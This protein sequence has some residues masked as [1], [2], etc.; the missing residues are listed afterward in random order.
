MKKLLEKGVFF[1][2]ADQYAPYS[3]Q[4]ETAQENFTFELIAGGASYAVTG[5]SSVCAQKDLVIPSF[6]NGLPVTKIKEQAFRQCNFLTSVVISEGITVIGMS[7]FYECSNLKSVRFPESLKVIGG[8]SFHS[9]AKLERIII[10]AKVESI[11]SRAFCACRGVKEFI[12]SPL[13]AKYQAIDGNLYTKDGTALLY[14]GVA[15]G[16]SSF[17]L[18]DGVR[19]IEEWAFT[20]ANALTE[21]VLP[22]GLVSIGYGAFSNCEKLSSVYYMGTKKEWDR[23]AINKSCND[24]FL[25]ARVYYYGEGKPLQGRDIWRYDGNGEPSVW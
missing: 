5:F 21:I 24:T 13:N 18:P 20:Y 12:V 23:I 1:Y 22:V 2:Q 8:W 4:G 17:R 14:Y 10:P 11:E 25:K 9:C 6:Y 3:G 19:D 7:A 15:K 16:E